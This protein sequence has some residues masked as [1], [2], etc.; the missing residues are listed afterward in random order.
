VGYAAG[1][2]DEFQGTGVWK[3]VKFQRET[4]ALEDTVTTTTPAATK[5]ADDAKK[6]T[7]DSK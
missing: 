3:G 2:S 7:Q 1:Q 5:L 4:T 6:V